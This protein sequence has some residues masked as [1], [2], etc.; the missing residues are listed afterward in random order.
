[1]N[2]LF[3]WLDTLKPHQVWRLC[4]GFTVAAWVAFFVLVAWSIG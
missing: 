1:M 3:L 4:I 2:A